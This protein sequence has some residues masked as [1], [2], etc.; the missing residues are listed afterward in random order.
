MKLSNIISPITIYEINT[1]DWYHI[2][3]LPKHSNLSFQHAIK[4][5]FVVYHKLS[6]N[7]IPIHIEIPMCHWIETCACSAHITPRSDL[8]CAQHPRLGRACVTSIIHENQVSSTFFCTVIHH[9]FI[10]NMDLHTQVTK[11][12]QIITCNIKNHTIINSLPHC[13]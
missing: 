6:Q 3:K 9:P 10:S 7:L 1:M 8:G 13:R 5:G 4:H 12:M 11:L 2:D